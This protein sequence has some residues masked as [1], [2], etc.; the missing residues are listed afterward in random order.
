MTLEYKWRTTPMDDFVIANK[1]LHEAS[2]ESG[3]P[4]GMLTGRTRGTKTVNRVRRAAIYKVHQQTELSTT[5][6]GLLFKRDHSTIVQSIQHVKK[7]MA[8][9]AE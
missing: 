1:I 5:E 7:E 8:N 4:L 2:A 6:I 9:A 3:I